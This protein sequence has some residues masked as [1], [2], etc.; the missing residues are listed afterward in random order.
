MRIGFTLYF[1]QPCSGHSNLCGNLMAPGTGF[2]TSFALHF[3]RFKRP[4]RVAAHLQLPLGSDS[5]EC[6]WAESITR[7]FWRAGSY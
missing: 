2:T 1:K 6:T 5:A 4:P 7:D 3:G